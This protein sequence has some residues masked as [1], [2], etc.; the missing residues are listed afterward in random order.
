MSAKVMDKKNRWRSKTVAF[1]MSPDE[2]LM[3][4][5]LSLLSGLSKQEYLINRVLQLDIV[6][7]GNPRTYK[8]LRNEL[9]SVFSE[10]KRLESISSEYDELISLIGFIAEILFGLK[11]G[12][13]VRNEKNDHS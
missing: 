1:R 5:R 4:D 13:N 7:V 9:E 3:L 11:E 2:A 12:V 8:M 10:L 6:V